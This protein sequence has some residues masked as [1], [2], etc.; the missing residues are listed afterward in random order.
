MESFYVCTEV[1]KLKVFVKSLNSSIT[2]FFAKHSIIFWDVRG[3][4]NRL[5]ENLYYGDEITFYSHSYSI[6]F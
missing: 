1:H 4:R 3:E 6:S 2:I 5:H